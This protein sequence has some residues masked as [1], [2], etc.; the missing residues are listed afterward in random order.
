[1]ENLPSDSVLQ[2]E[3]NGLV[4]AVAENQD[5]TLPS[6]LALKSHPLTQVVLTVSVSGLSDAGRALASSAPYAS[7]A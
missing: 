4:Q 1:M 6:V 3:V 7:L 5:T 2:V